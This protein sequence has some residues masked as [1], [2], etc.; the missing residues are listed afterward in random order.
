MSAIK[1]LILTTG[2][3]LQTRSFCTAQNQYHS[4]V[5]KGYA[6]EIS[7][8]TFDSTTGDVYNIALRKF[9]LLKSNYA[10]IVSAVL[11]DD[12]IGY[13]IPGLIAHLDQFSL[14]LQNGKNGNGDTL[15]IIRRTGNQSLTFSKIN[16]T[17]FRGTGIGGVIRYDKAFNKFLVNKYF[18]SKLPLLRLSASYYVTDHR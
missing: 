11:K 3:L 10:V 5:I 17:A 7:N 9:G 14:L 16:V 15:K 12:S 4:N 2:I 8:I 1:V 13:H 18:K 6:L